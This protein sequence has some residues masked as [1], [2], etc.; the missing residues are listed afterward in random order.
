MEAVQR[1]GEAL[2]ATTE[3]RT[4]APAGSTYHTCLCFGSEMKN[5]GAGKLS[6]RGLPWKVAL[7][8]CQMS[9]DNLFVRG[10]PPGG[11]PNLAKIGFHVDPL[12]LA[13]C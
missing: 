6:E 5:A 10:P 9:S 11:G 12:V 7:V 1:R 13:C 4:D 8:D 3:M 2:T